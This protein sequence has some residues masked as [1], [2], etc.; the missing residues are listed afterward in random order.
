MNRITQILGV[1]ST[2]VDDLDGSNF[3]LESGLQNNHVRH[4]DPTPGRWISE[5]L[6]SYDGND[7]NMTS[8]R[9]PVTG[10]AQ[11][12]TRSSSPRVGL[13]RGQLYRS[14]QLEHAAIC[15]VGD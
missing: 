4:F 15:E 3:D 9:R 1:R 10:S 11:E 14:H 13:I 6:I 8:L 7:A 12:R 2:P 5:E